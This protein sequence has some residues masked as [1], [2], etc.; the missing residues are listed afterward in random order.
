MKLSKLAV[1]TAILLPACA[2]FTARQEV[3]IPAMQIA[4]ESIRPDVMRGISHEPEERHA[5]LVSIELDFYEALS[6]GDIDALAAI[7]FHTL[8]LLALDGIDRRLQAG[9]LH[10]AVVKILIRQLDKFHEAYVKVVT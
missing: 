2:G 3:L 1:I 4:Y 8:E 6:A 5:I 10:P 7:P 9:D